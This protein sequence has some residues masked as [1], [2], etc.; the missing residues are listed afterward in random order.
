[1]AIALLTQL[2]LPPRQ[3]CHK[4]AGGESELVGT[5]VMGGFDP[6]EYNIFIDIQNNR[7]IEGQKEFEI[8][9]DETLTLCSQL[10]SCSPRVLSFD[11]AYD[12]ISEPLD[13]DEEDLTAKQ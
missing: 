10:V 2:S 3:R 7:V 12:E 5:E 9:D 6:A 11:L 13:E 1:M 4:L 8:S